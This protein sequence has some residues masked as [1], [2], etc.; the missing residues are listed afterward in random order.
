MRHR[1]VGS[2]CSILL[3]STI[4]FAQETPAPTCEAQVESLYGDLLKERLIYE[5]P[6]GTWTQ[7]LTAL[8]TQLRVTKDAAQMANQMTQQRVEDVAIQ[9][10]INRQTAQQ[11]GT[12]MQALATAQARIKELEAAQGQTPQAQR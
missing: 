12:T 9:K 5:V 4:A 2:I 3:W 10:E 7:H 1:V 8:A 6:G 11:L